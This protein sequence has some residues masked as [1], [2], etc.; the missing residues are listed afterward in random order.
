MAFLPFGSFGQAD[1]TNFEKFQTNQKSNFWKN[2]L[3][4]L[5][6]NVRAGTS[7]ILTIYLSWKTTFV[8]FFEIWHRVVS[9]MIEYNLRE[10]A[11]C[12]ER[13]L[14]SMRGKSGLVQRSVTPLP[15]SAGQRQSALA[16]WPNLASLEVG[17]S[18]FNLHQ[19]E[20]KSWIR[21]IKSALWASRKSFFI[22]LVG[23]QLHQIKVRPK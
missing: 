13:H 5:S 11:L 15:V 21:N 10:F 16:A 14:E 22:F 19:N 17:K 18:D 3:M 6:G 9:T 4:K 7:I 1:E 8:F 20:L 2:E 23:A 12:Y